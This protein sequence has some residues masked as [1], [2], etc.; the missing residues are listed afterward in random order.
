MTDN[1]VTAAKAV[2][3]GYKIKNHSAEKAKRFAGKFFIY[4]ALVLFALWILA[5]FSLVLV[6]SL[7]TAKEANSLDFHWWPQEGFTLQ[8]YEAIFEFD[9]G[10]A[11]DGVP[12]II[13][14]FL[15]TLWII[16][17]PTVLGLF[18]SAISAYAFAKLRFKGKNWLFSLLLFT[19]MI[20]GTILLTPSYTIYSQLNWIDTPLPL[21]IP[22]MFGAAT[23]VFFMRQFY[24]GIPTELMEAAKLDGMGYFSM[25]WR[26]MVPLS[27]PA[28]L[29]QGLLG[30]IGGYNDYLAPLIYLQSPEMYTL[31]IT[32][33]LLKSE[34][35]MTNTPAMMAA[36]TVSIIPTIVLYIVAQKYFVEG[37]AT[38]GM[39]L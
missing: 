39:K 16:I 3:S 32:M 26:I 30:F 33:N 36:T 38:S 25:F 14:G 7:K 6:T 18:C 35:Q 5:P 28:L 9:L 22:G 21:M 11:I 34:F 2:P 13:M 10:S 1:N 12:I 37:I 4:F 17:P 27:V 23:C 8:G 31:Q 20:P 24:T 29:A 15:N 19:M